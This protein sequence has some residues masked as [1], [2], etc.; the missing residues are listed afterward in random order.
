[1]SKGTIAGR[2]PMAVAVEKDKEYWW[3]SCGLSKSQ[4]FCD[5]SHNAEKR[6]SPVQWVAPK[7]GT[8]YFCTCKQTG[9]APFCDGSHGTV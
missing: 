8:K 4:P 2:E 7:S 6:F 3:C 1:M 9:N 5:G